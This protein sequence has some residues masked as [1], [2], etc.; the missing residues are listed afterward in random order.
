MGIGDKGQNMSYPKSMYKGSWT[1]DAINAEHKIV[2]DEKREAA[3]RADGFVDGRQLLDSP[4][5]SPVKAKKKS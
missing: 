5:E 1:P 3:L 2:H 4:P